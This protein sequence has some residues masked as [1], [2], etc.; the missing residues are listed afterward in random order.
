MP[1]GLAGWL[2]HRYLLEAGTEIGFVGG[3]SSVSAA[4]AEK[5]RYSTKHHTPSPLEPCRAHQKYSEQ[6]L[7][8][9]KQINKRKKIP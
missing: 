8:K 1:F 9:P 7:K 4:L 6:I 2:S 3:S 5:E